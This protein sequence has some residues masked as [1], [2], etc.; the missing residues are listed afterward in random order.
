[1]LRNYQNHHYHRVY[2]KDITD[3]FPSLTLSQYSANLPVKGNISIN[4]SCIGGWKINNILKNVKVEITDGDM[5]GDAT[6]KITGL[7]S[8]HQDYPSIIEFVNKSYNNI[9]ATFTIN[10]ID[11]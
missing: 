8:Y 3:E 5:N 9:K 7:A 4:I 6:I 1:M 11:N 2:A 10:F